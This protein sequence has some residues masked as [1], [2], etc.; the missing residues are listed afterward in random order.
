ML[1]ELFIAKMVKRLCIEGASLVDL[2]GFQ[3]KIQNE[4]LQPPP[5]FYLFLNWHKRFD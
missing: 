2:A 4:G 5:I 3:S 1:Q